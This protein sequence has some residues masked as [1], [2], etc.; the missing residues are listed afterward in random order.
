[1]KILAWTF[2]A[3]VVSACVRTDK[4]QVISGKVESMPTISKLVEMR[5]GYRGTQESMEE[6]LKCWNDEVESFVQASATSKNVSLPM[7]WPIASTLD[8]RLPQSARHFFEVA[9]K[10]GFRSLYDRQTGTSRFFGA[11]L[12]LFSEYAPA[13]F[14]LWKSAFAG[15][16]APDNEYY[17][18]D[19]TQRKGV[20]LRAQYLDRMLV[21]GGE[22]GGATYLLIPDE[23]SK[24]GELETQ[25]LHH[26]GLIVRFKSF[27]HLLA[28]LYLEEHEKMAGRD[29]SLGHL[30][31]YPGDLAQTCVAH[32]ID[33]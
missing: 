19:R 33:L 31:Y 22:T 23:I 24:D 3:L 2:A 14:E 32:V 18:Y 6:F 5:S 26:G 15:V 11:N 9:P 7:P 4:D 21:V 27:A 30:Y 10:V 1:M 29:A 13:D 20:R 25:F 8:S 12:K 28:N 16:P 17:R